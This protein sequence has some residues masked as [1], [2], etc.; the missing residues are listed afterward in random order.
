[1]IKKSGINDLEFSSLA[2]QGTD[3]IVLLTEV[4]EWTDEAFEKDIY[5]RFR[6]SLFEEI[7][8]IFFDVVKAESI[9]FVSNLKQV[10]ES[11]KYNEDAYVV[12]EEKKEEYFAIIKFILDDLSIQFFS[13][14]DFFY[15]ENEKHAGHHKTSLEKILA[16]SENSVNH[17]DMLKKDFYGKIEIVR[18]LFKARHGKGHMADKSFKNFV[19]NRILSDHAFVRFI[20]KGKETYDENSAEKDM[21]LDYDS[22][23]KTHRNFLKTKN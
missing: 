10:F 21:P 23:M 3:E 20:R 16:L 5:Q 12:S 18:N 6:Y 19:E 4:K 14:P 2:I 7:Q 11:V 13:D 1:M 17:R 8:K 22:F 15:E 9:K